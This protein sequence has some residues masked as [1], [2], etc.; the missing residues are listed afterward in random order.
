[1]RRRR[2]PWAL[3]MRSRT[4]S[5]TFAVFQARSAT[6]QP[7]RRCRPFSPSVAARGLCSR[8]FRRTRRRLVATVT[9]PSSAVGTWA[10]HAV[11]AGSGRA[12]RSPRAPAR[13][14]VRA[15]RRRSTRARSTRLSAR[16]TRGT[17]S[18]REGVDHRRADDEELVDLTLGTVKRDLAV[19]LPSSRAREPQRRRRGAVGR[20]SR[21]GSRRTGARASRSTPPSSGDFDSSNKYPLSQARASP[22]RLV[23]MASGETLL[24]GG[25]DRTAT[26]S[27]RWRRSTLRPSARGTGGSRSS[28][29]LARTPS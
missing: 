15:H 25:V 19:G 10:A 26:S 27:A 18:S 1:M 6:F 4:L 2:A 21:E 12:I 9:A 11:L 22:R 3:R 28:K 23:V 14:A 8:G 16:S 17:R 20:S 29:C 7:H 13:L 5:A 24:V